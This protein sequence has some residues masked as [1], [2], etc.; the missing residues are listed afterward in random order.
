MTES[1]Q[2]ITLEKRDGV[3]EVFLNRPEKSNAMGPDL[4]P[5][6]RDVFGKIDADDD[7]RAVVVGGAGKNFCA[8]LDLAASAQEFGGTMGSGEMS[9]IFH[10]ILGLQESL[11]AI[12]ECRKPVIAAVHRACIGGGLDL[13]AACDVR[14][15]TED[16]RF[17]LREAR[18]AMIADLGSL[19]R[20]PAIIGQGHTRELAF[21]GKDID[22]QRALRINLVNDIYPDR[23]KCLDAAR[24]LAREMAAAAPL[25]VQG[26]KEVMNYSR[27]KSVRDGLHYAAARSCL[28]LKSND[29]AEAM[30]AF[31]KKKEPEFKGK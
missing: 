25:A 16:A 27:D 26:A 30:S 9:S 12:E 8:G 31:M 1:Y 24:E 23:E 7:V 19:N 13:I 4:W 20:L 17:S 22:A 14:L 28:I 5:E 10:H 29:L 18:V 15:C 2:V 11:N 3:A 21:T 6:L